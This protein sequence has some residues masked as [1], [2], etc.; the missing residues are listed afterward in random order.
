[1]IIALLHILWEKHG[2]FS[3]DCHKI[4]ICHVLQLAVKFAYYCFS[5]PQQ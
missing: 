4:E 5:L 3:Q 2:S 1:M